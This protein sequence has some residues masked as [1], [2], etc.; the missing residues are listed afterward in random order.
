MLKDSP[1]IG[2][3]EARSKAGTVT[4]MNV[5]GMLMSG[6]IITLVKRGKNISFSLTFSNTGEDDLNA[7]AVFK[8]YRKKNGALVGEFTTM[9]QKVVSNETVEFVAYMNSGVLLPMV[10]FV[11][12]TG[13]FYTKHIV[14]DTRVFRKDFRVVR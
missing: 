14:H 8:C 5:R 2:V 6:H 10:Y 4:A 12:S 1:L 13:R 9:P 11:E 7:Y 3:H